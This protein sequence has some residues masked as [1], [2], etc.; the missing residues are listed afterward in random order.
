[1]TN[2]KDSREKTPT[3]LAIYSNFETGLKILLDHDAKR[4]KST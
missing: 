2:V 3:H 4:E 1:L